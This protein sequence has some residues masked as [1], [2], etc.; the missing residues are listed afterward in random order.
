MPDAIK[1]TGTFFTR[2]DKSY[3]TAHK[4]TY[5]ILKC[6][7]FVS[8]RVYIGL[9]K[10]NNTS[11]TEANKKGEIIGGNKMKKF[12]T[13]AAKFF[14]AAIAAALVFSNSGIKAFA[15][16]V[17]VGYY[18]VKDGVTVTDKTEGGKTVGVSTDNFETVISAPAKTYTVDEDELKKLI[19][20]T[21]LNERT[22]E[23]TTAYTIE[24]NDGQP[25]L[26]YTYSVEAVLKE[27]GLPTEF[28]GKTID[29]YVLKK[30]NDGYH[31]DGV[32]L[33]II[34]P[35]VTYIP[36][37]PA[38][39]EP[40]DPNPNGNT[41]DEEKD[42]DPV[43]S[44]SPV[45]P[46]TP[47][48]T[49][50]SGDLPGNGTPSEEPAAPA[51]PETPVV[52]TTPANPETP[53]QPDAP[54]ADTPATDAP[55]ED[56]P[57][58]EAPVTESDDKTPAVEAPVTTIVPVIPFIIVNNFDNT[59]DVDT[60]DVTAPE[61]PAAEEETS[62]E[63][64][65]DIVTTDTPE[66]APADE[67]PEA[68]V[69]EEEIVDVDLVTTPESAVEEDVEEEDD[70]ELD[71][72]ETPQGDVLPQTGVLSAAVFYGIGSLCVALGGTVVAKIRRKDEE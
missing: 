39:E 6:I 72:I 16:T 42:D 13:I 62:E 49:P 52:P 56:T 50:A 63:I 55:A 59:D 9:I 54:A 57:A 31:V 26:H 47:G 21:N 14:A 40:E 28:N 11:E 69:E 70:V 64:I 18:V 36:D 48:Q 17:G 5:K 15:G 12:G 53:L 51:E 10:L 67:E 68:E 23:A 41:E 4:D 25:T 2:Q 22:N 3:T 27:L 38:T 44:N 19:K 7:H 8:P 58:T 60:E 66:G 34:A 65:D 45:Q 33:N 61:E 43:I 35:E 32:N 29:W 24:V 37:T 30:E 46:Q 20:A 71:V 1:V